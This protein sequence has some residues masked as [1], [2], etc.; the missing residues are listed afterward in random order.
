[1]RV[2]HVLLVR[3]R[4]SVGGIFGL[5]I[6]VGD[7]RLTRPA[8]VQWRCGLEM[9]LLCSRRRSSRMAIG[10]SWRSSGCVPSLKRC[11]A[12]ATAKKA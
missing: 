11:R 10:A 4:A 5:G 7:A 6:D 2:N 8:G 3:R 12:V 1:V 9:M